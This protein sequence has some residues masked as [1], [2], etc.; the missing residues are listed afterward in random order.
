[1]IRRPRSI[2]VPPIGLAAD[3]PAATAERASAISHYTQH[4]P[5]ADNLDFRAYSHASV[6]EALGTLFGSKCA[7]CEGVTKGML[8]FDVEHFRPKG[9]IANDDHTVSFPGYWWLASEWTN[10]LPSCIDC[11]RGRY[12]RLDKRRTVKF[13]KENLFP[14]SAGSVRA[15][16]PGEEL[17][18]VPLLLNPCVDYPSQYLAFRYKADGPT[19]HSCIAT[20]KLDEQTIPS[21]RGNASIEV[22]GLNRPGL[23]EERGRRVSELDWH[24]RGIENLWKMARE[25]QPSGLADQLIKKCRVDLRELIKVYL[26][27]DA[28]YAAACRAHFHSWKES[29]SVA[30]KEMA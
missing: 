15:S 29:L 25:A 17:N 23:I 24:L 30:S 21:E 7:Y 16:A 3:N 9:E 2:V 1:M 20:A 22:Y 4:P 11:N 10:L 26:N 27:W 28:P 12:H 13:G 18:E 14:L 6:K 19:G 8:P 5:P